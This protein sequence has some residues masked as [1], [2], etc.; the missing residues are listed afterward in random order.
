MKA[1]LSVRVR[2]GEARPIER[3]ALFAERSAS[4]PPHSRDRASTRRAHGAQ[5]ASHR[6][7]LD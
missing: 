7:Q 2:R 5:N 4:Q 1:R 6:P 3:P